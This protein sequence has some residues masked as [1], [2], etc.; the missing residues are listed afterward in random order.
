MT[1]QQHISTDTLQTL[2][3][4]PAILFWGNP[5]GQVAGASRKA[6]KVF[7]IPLYPVNPDQWIG[8]GLL[9]QTE[10]SGPDPE[11]FGK[12]SETFTALIQ[13]TAC[14]NQGMTT[15][16]RPAAGNFPYRV[17]TQPAGDPENPIVLCVMEPLPE[18]SELLRQ[19]TVAEVEAF[20]QM[21]EAVARANQLAVMA[22]AAS[23]AKSAFLASMSHELR[24][25]MN[26]IIGT[27]QLLLETPLNAEQR[28]YV[29]LALRS[30]Q[31]LLKMINNMLDFSRLEAGKAQT[32]RVR[33]DLGEL[34]E[35]T[36]DRCAPLFAG[37]PVDFTCFME[38]EVRGVYLGDPEK[39]RQMMI[40]MVGNAAKFTESGSVS[41]LL[42]LADTPCS[43]VRRIRFST[44]DTGP[45]LSVEAC[46]RVFDP[47][48]QLEPSGVRRY[49]GTGLGLAICRQ[50]ALLL[51]GTIGVESTPGKGSVFWFEIPLEFL[52]PVPL[53]QVCAA[54]NPP[55]V[56]VVDPG[57]ESRHTLMACFRQ[58]GVRVDGI[59]D[60]SDAEAAL[61]RMIQ[62]GA[63]YNFLVVSAP[64][65][66]SGETRPDH[67]ALAE[68]LEIR[69]LPA[70]SRL[71]DPGESPQPVFLVKPVW[72]RDIVRLLTA[73]CKS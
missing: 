14:C 23:A 29:Q 65:G 10:P 18:E 37:K 71:P 26:A 27:A 56:L 20:R 44:R 67:P 45:G 46:R 24:T 2:Q 3:L 42:E 16:F 30:A 62:D 41:V 70:A 12:V 34:F 28:E 50:I 4:V 63:R 53:P 1:G 31:D 43:G 73:F 66:L 69:I 59:A 48:T 55:R 8:S 38:P 52:E 51:G 47:F 33:F 40:N 36:M 21:E 54:G 35:E 61:A 9:T 6:E 57:M 7:G 60:W 39:I 32:E 5:E 11:E 58:V 72:P 68:A 19:A 15:L 13:H 49:G 17:I 64:A 22:E 25:P